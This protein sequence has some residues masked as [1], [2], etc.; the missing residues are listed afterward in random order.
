MSLILGLR[1]PA[2]A[3]K[4]AARCGERMK[5]QRTAANGLPFSPH[6]PRA[7]RLAPEKR[8]QAAAVQGSYAK[9]DMSQKSENSNTFR[10]HVTTCN[11]KLKRVAEIDKL[12]HVFLICR[13]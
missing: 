10:E 5:S 6:P 2:A 1:Q 11:M 12:R 8:Q 13:S 3:F 7:S 4:P 9:S